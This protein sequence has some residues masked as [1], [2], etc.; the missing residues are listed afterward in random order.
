MNPLP[1]EQSWMIT[2][3]LLSDLQ[4][5]GYEIPHTI[6]TELG[7]VRSQIGFYKRDK[8]A[9]EMM[10]E[11]MNAEMSLTRI[12]ES[13]ISLAKKVGPTYVEKW[14]IALKK[15]NKGE[16]V[17]EVPQLGS[18]FV[19]NTPPGFS[20]G[21]ITLTKP[22]SEERVQDIAE[23]FNLIIEFEDDVTLSFYG[24]KENVQKGLREM[25]P[26]FNEE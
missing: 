22:I 6:N 4:K 26:F 9:P 8:T 13:L 17:V 5:K 11:Y 21:R 14:E 7:I 19:I 10:K 24:D 25:A 16:K 15:A 23:Y 2:V 3:D 20:S 1:I 18:H 12:Q